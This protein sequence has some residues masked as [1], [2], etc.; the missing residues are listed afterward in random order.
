MNHAK[1]KAL[2]DEDANFLKVVNEIIRDPSFDDLDESDIEEIIKF[3]TY[4]ARLSGMFRCRG[5]VR[6]SQGMPLN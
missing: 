6:K 3:F 5:D 2:L 1:I 4:A